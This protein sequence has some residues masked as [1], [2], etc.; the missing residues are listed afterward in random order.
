MLIAQTHGQDPPLDTWLV[1]TPGPLVHISVLSLGPSHTMYPPMHTV[2]QI[3][4]CAV[5]WSL[6][7]AEKEFL[8][9]LGSA[10]PI[11]EA[12]LGSGLN[13]WIAAWR[14]RGQ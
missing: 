11:P 14:P 3:D 4:T 1:R 9:A 6:M 12:T 13:T 2:R 7:V 8:G 5:F 10:M